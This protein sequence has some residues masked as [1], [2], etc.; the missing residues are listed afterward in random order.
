MH[1]LL[2]KVLSFYPNIFEP[3]KATGSM[4]N[5]YD[6]VIRGNARL[7]TRYMDDI[8]MEINRSQIEAKLSEINNLRPN[9]AL[10]IEREVDGSLPF[11]DMQLI[12]DDKSITSKW[13]S[14]PTDTGLILNYHSLAPRRYKKS[15]VSGFVHRIFRACSTW[16]HFHNSMQRAKVM[17]ESNQ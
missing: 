14:K 11:L 15:V 12:H 3:A 10:T 9:L 16:S 2:Q 5:Q 6:C 7:F 1:K 13:Y 8:L 4:L 17:L